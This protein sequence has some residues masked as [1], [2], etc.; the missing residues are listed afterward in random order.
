MHEGTQFVET[1]DFQ[2]KVAKLTAQQKDPVKNRRGEHMEVAR[3]LDK[4]RRAT[5]DSAEIGARGAPFWPT[6]TKEVQRD[7]NQQW[8]CQSAATIA[9]DAAN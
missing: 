5:E 7:W 9:G 2:I 6:D 4:S 3:N 1:S 8:A